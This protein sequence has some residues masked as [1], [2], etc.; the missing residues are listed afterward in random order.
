LLEVVMM[1]KSFVDRFAGRSWSGAVAVACLGLM[2]GCGSK[3]DPTPAASGS[4]LSGT[5]ERGKYLVDYLLVCGECHTPTGPD[6]NPVPGKY[7]A[8]SRSYDFKYGT[9]SISVYAENL[10]SH[11]VEGLGMWTDDQIRTAI[12]KGIDDEHVS[13]WPIMP[14]P[15]YSQLA[16]DDVDSIIKYLRTVPS[17][18]DVVPPDT[19]GDPDPPAPSINDSDI[20][21]ATLAKTDPLYASSER[22]RYLATVACAQCHTPQTAPGIPDFSKPFA[23]GR[24]YKSRSDLKEAVSTNITPHATGL[25][26]WTVDD[27]KASIKTNTEKGT[28]RPLCSTMPGGMHRMGELT[29]ADLQD[30][31]VYVANLPPV[32]NGP[33]KCE[34]N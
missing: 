17:S 15:E 4:T 29:D 8:G 23:G 2:V 7:L 27:I 14:Y 1:S 19:I 13:M 30:I 24:P 16:K 33:F 22:G 26:G 34:G 18:P 11:P 9:Q 32:M 3:S 28:A 21:H 25:A 20:P 5:V 10:T 31:A 6:G 12:T